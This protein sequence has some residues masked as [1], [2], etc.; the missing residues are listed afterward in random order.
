MKFAF[1][2]RTQ[3]PEV[4]LWFPGQPFPKRPFPVPSSML[5]VFTLCRPRRWIFPDSSHQSRNATMSPLN[6]PMTIWS[7]LASVQ[8]LVSPEGAAPVEISCPIDGREIKSL[9][10]RKYQEEKIVLYSK[11]PQKLPHGH[12]WSCCLSWTCL[13]LTTGPA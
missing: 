12:H 2:W 5:F 9:T 13:T 1:F 3:N 4:R 10:L 8:K 11:H 6:S 7:S